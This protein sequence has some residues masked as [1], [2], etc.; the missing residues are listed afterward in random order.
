MPTGSNLRATFRA[1]AFLAI[2]GFLIVTWPIPLVL[3]RKARHWVRRFWSRFSCRLLGI[4]VGAQGAPFTACPTML[5][6][7]HVSYLDVIVLGCFTDATFIAKDEVD[8]WPFF[9]YIARVTGT[10][11]IKRHWRQAKIQRD[12]I[13]A[14]MRAHESFVLFAEGTSSNGLGVKPFKT[15][16]L[17]VAEPWVLDRPAAAQAVTIAYLRLADGRPITLDTCDLYA[18]YDEMTFLPHLWQVLRQKGVVV[19][20]EFRE[21]V[22]SWS[23]QSRKVLGP[24]LRDEIAHRLAARREAAGEGELLTAPAATAEA[25]QTR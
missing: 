3:G 15:S 12:L 9:G 4:R 13:A 20:V 18:W 22:L 21:P 8:G 23:V 6:A 24:K 7:N 1:A 17:S 16:L 25:M 2:T 10:L 11:F 14:R 19:E 5:V